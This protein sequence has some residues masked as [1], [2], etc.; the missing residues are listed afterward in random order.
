MTTHR[1][2]DA[3]ARLD[4]VA[5]PDGLRDETGELLAADLVAAVA[6]AF[7]DEMDA[8]EA[9]AGEVLL[10]HDRAGLPAELAAAVVRGVQ[11][12][13]AT[14][15]DLG[16]CP[17]DLARFASGRLATPAIMIAA[18]PGPDGAVGLG[19]LRAGAEDLTVH[20]GLDAVLDRAAHYLA[21]GLAP[22][23]SPASLREVD[24]LPDYAA[25]LLAL[26]DLAGIRPLTVVVDAGHGAAAVTIPAVFGTDSGPG[27]SPAAGTT[28]LPITVIP[29]SFD[30][31]ADA[32]GR[33]QEIDPFDPGSLVDLRNAVVANA[34]DLGLG[35]DSD[36]GRCVVI[37]EN[38]VLV[39]P[40]AIGAL[41]ARRAIARERARRPGPVAAPDTA[42]DILVAHSLIVSLRVP[43]T[44][45]AAGA[46]P[47][48]TESAPALLRA[49]MRDDGAVFGCG[50]AADYYF[51]EF[52]DS[53]S[54]LLAA[55]N[56]LAELGGQAHPLSELAVEFSP[57]A[58]SGEISSPV[59]DL[60]DAYAGIV[61]AY[62]GVAEFDEL[63]GLTVTG[64]T[65]ADEPFWWFNVRPSQTEPLLRLTVEAATPA[66]MIRVRDEVLA[67]IRGE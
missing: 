40:S 67:L 42:P 52:C 15:V 64:M 33:P 25:T 36:A 59:E 12:R 6:A 56:L 5:R 50:H 49:R 38:G 14:I 27:S 62:T 35:F 43:E 57:Y 23:A 65:S 53:G 37:E 30:A 4:A 9:G 55:L 63:D 44:I 24:L 54:G 32:E 21:E 46:I 60:P 51:R 34:A 41:L 7:V 20:T 3:R 61:E 2:D 1:I 13:G 29:L 48:R 26:V 17:T 66:A 47:V 22:V 16:A 19:F 45:E 8:G 28:P 11:A 18:G 10:G 58:R 31:G 39:D